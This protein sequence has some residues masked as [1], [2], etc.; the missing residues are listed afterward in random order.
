M[1]DQ[2]TGIEGMAGQ[3]G[4]GL[5]EPLHIRGHWRAD[6]Y[7]GDWTAEE[8]DA[9]LAGAPVE[10]QEGDNL[11]VNVG[12]QLLLDLLIGA[13]GTTYA[14]AN[15]YIGVGDS[16]T[17]AAAGQT[18][19]Q[20]STNRFKRVMDATF[21]SR[22]GQTLTFRTTYATSEA[23]F[24]INEAG[25]FNGG[26]AFATGTMLNRIVQ[27]LGTKTSATTLQVTVTLTIS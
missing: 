17:A 20:A 1:D 9:G 11:L 6:Y 24:A 26:P 14:N 5:H 3:L 8:I 19:L 21:P 10:T 2:G 23:N 4:G 25:V 27:S 12:I 18:D 22:S 13:G 16:S 15:T 7:A